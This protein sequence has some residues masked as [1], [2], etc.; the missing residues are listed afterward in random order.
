MAAPGRHEQRQVPLSPVRTDSTLDPSSLGLTLSL[1]DDLLSVKRFEF[2]LS[3]PAAPPVPPASS[4]TSDDPTSSNTGRKSREAGFEERWRRNELRDLALQGVPDAPP[5]IRPGTYEALLSLPSPAQSSEQYALFLESISSQ[6]RSLDPP[7]AGSSTAGR[8]GADGGKGENGSGRDLGARVDKV[9]REIEQDVER[10]FASLAWFGM[11]VET[12]PPE[13]DA[14]AKEAPDANDAV[15]DRLGMLHDLDHSIASDLARRPPSATE[16]GPNDAA[17][18]DELPAGANSL[19]SPSENPTL[20]L[21]IPSSAPNDTTSV[22]IPPSPNTPTVRDTPSLGGKTAQGATTPVPLSEDSRR[23]R[24]RS[25]RDLLVRPLFVYAFLNPGLSYVQGMNYLAAVSFYVFSLA[26]STQT[27]SPPSEPSATTRSPPLARGSTLSLAESQTFF[28]ISA[29]LSQLQDLYVPLHDGP[30]AA[31]SN[32]SRGGGGGTGLGAMLER[33]ANLLRWLDPNV[34]DALERKGIE[35]EPFGIRWLTTMFANEFMLPDLVRIWDRIVSLYPHESDPPEALSPVL[36]HL[37]DLALAIVVTHR[38]TI[39]S[40]FSSAQKLYSV[41]QSPSIEGSD[42]DK[43]LALAWDIRERRLGRGSSAARADVPSTPTKRASTGAGAFAGML[44]SRLFSATTPN[45]SSSP[46]GGSPRSVSSQAHD[47]E[48]ADTASSVADSQQSRDRLETRGG[49]RFGSIAFSSPRSSV[50]DPLDHNVTM[51]EG[52]LLPPPPAR[53][54]EQESIASLV[55]AE[56]GAP[57]YGIDDDDDDDLDDED[58]DTSTTSLGG[59]FKS[60]M[61]RI[62]ASDAAANLS[63]RAT[64]LQIAA[65]QSASTTAS[66][67]SSSDAA[68]HL[69]KTQTNLAVQ[70]QLIKNRVTAEQIGTR[71]RDVGERFMA[72][73]GSERGHGGGE[74]LMETPFTPPSVFSGGTIRRPRPRATSPGESAGA[75]GHGSSPSLSAPRPL[76]LSGS[77]RRAHN[78]SIDESSSSPGSSRPSS[79]ASNRSPSVSPVLSRSTH[80]PLLSPDMSIPPLSRSPSQSSHGRSSSHFDTPTR[81]VPASTFRPRSSSQAT[82]SPYQH[83]D[84]VPLALG[85]VE[86]AS[87]RLRRGLGQSQPA[88]PSNPSSAARPSNEGRGWTLSDAPV[89]SAPPPDLREGEFSDRLAGLAIQIPGASQDSSASPAVAEEDKPISPPP[90]ASSLAASQAAEHASVGSSEPKESGSVPPGP[91]A[92]PAPSESPF[93]PPSEPTESPFSPPDLE[94]TETPFVPPTFTEPAFEPP[95]SSSPVP[96]PDEPLATGPTAETLSRPSL[97]R[98]K[99]VRRPG[100]NK[101]RSSRGSS[102]A[103]SVDF[104]TAGSSTS[105]SISRDERRI[106]SEFLTR[107]A[108]SRKTRGPGAETEREDLGEKRSSRSMAAGEPGANRSSMYDEFSFLASYGDEQ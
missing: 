15:W 105:G 32:L 10:T 52:K 61:S 78:G 106:A 104:G 14:S 20:T 56:L 50:L 93:S 73:T 33:L 94:Q 92:G 26:P 98:S 86:S 82:A 63:K 57:E 95:R 11:P 58:P 22:D 90:R 87:A 24:P 79:I 7:E 5:S 72:S 18:A 108:S 23:R 80:L 77:A 6:L 48:L 55:E 74:G 31:L 40:P 85:R 4:S 21:N 75:G 60:S 84:D 45:S 96:D 62:A 42:V 100:V 16:S 35:V 27:S 34:A 54:G 83:D 107:S 67:L 89:R 13:D 91:R 36:A 71:V 102:F 47:F 3:R 81:S 39:L 29:L 70:A 1:L 99:V 28:A 37:L 49:P 51:I 69:L 9:L 103:G 59:W 68:A 25:R 97:S 46:H 2:L 17:G 76:L 64:N 30:A 38:S 44:K 19:P 101:K 88:V 53:M 65:A 66:R 12:G 41:L 8:D 43:L